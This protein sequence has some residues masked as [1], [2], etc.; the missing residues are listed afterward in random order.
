MCPVKHNERIER[1][2]GTDTNGAS[3][4]CRRL[5]EFFLAFGHVPVIEDRTGGT[6]YFILIG[7]DDALEAW[8]ARYTVESWYADPRRPHHQVALRRVQHQRH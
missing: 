1:K 6:V 7:S 4:L 2:G 3:D 8:N 5:H